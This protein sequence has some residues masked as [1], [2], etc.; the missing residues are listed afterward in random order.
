MLGENRSIPSSRMQDPKPVGTPEAGGTEL[1]D[2]QAK[3]VRKVQ[4]SVVRGP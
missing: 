4:P 3:W 1:R 2:V